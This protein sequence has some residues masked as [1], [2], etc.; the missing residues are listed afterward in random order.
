MEIDGA[1]E[2]AYTVT[3]AGLERR[4][5]GRRL[6]Y[7]LDESHS[8]FASIQ[9]CNTDEPNTCSVNDFVQT[10]AALIAPNDKERSR[11][12]RVVRFSSRYRLAFSLLNEDASAGNGVMAWNVRKGIQGASLSN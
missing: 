12:N 11:Q 5:Q 4:I 7:P 2:D 10:L 6:A 8:T 9:T 3:A 1:K